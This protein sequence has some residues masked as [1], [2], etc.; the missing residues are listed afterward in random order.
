MNQP[1]KIATCLWYDNQG[2]EAAKLYTSLVPNS[3]ITACYRSDPETPP[4][5]VEFNLD[6]VPYQALNGGPHFKHSEAA[7]IVVYTEDQQETD[8]LWR[9]LIADGGSEGRCAWLKDR[10]GL[11]WQIVPRRFVELASSPDRAAAGRVMRAMQGM[12]KL[13][14]AALEAAFNEE[15]D[16]A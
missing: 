1:T 8:R 9:A 4:L 15:I 12:N 10:F 16:N 14:I 13:D 5:I 7:S 2:E 11:S 3:A 6:G